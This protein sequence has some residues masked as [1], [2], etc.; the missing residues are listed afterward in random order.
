MTDATVVGAR[1]VSRWFDVGAD[2]IAAFADATDDWN[3]IHTD[4]ARAAQ[5]PFGG[6]VA[7][8]FLTLSLLSAM[9]Y[10]ALRMTGEGGN[11]SVNYGLDRVRFV[12]PV[13]AG[14]RLRAVFVLARLT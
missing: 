1:H 4:P 10:D 3:W 2:R 11:P 6:P 9:A 8:G 14:S 5:S 12:A 13:P 7:H